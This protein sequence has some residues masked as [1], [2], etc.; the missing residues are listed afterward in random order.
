MM[1][2]MKRSLPFLLVL[3]SVSA[4]VS[5]VEKAQGEMELQGAKKEVYFQLTKD[6]STRI[7][8]SNFELLYDAEKRFIYLNAETTVNTSGRSLSADLYQFAVEIVDPDQELY[9][10]SSLEDPEI[11]FR[12]KKGKQALLLKPAMKKG[13]QSIHFAI[14]MAALDLPEGRTDVQVLYWLY[15]GSA[16][17]LITNRKLDI[18]MPPTSWYRISID[19]LKVSPGQSYD[20]AIWERSDTECNS[21]LYYTTQQMGYVLHQSK[22]RDNS[23]EILQESA[24]FKGY[25]DMPVTLQLL[26]FDP[27]TKDELLSQVELGPQRQTVQSEHFQI[28]IR[29]ITQ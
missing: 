3:F 15:A 4:C 9:A 25:T 8:I 13:N 24:D 11:R 6:T 12:S 16:K 17:Q 21:D 26:D 7:S 14:P 28:E 10:Y 23:C 22:V 29:Q 19:Y 5:E 20:K 18:Q 1:W 2:Q 27:L